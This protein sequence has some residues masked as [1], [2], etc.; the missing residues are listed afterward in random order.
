[1]LYL[2]LSTDKSLLKELWEYFVDRYF[3][4]DMPY[5]ENINISST[6]LNTL[7]L[8]IVG[9]TFGI[10][11]TAISTIFN[12]RYV[13]DFIRKLLYEECYDANSAKTLYELGYLKSPSIRSMIKT[14]GSLSRWVR[15]VEEDEFLAEQDAKRAEFE[16]AHKGDPNKPKFKEAE[17]KRELNTM[18]FYL[19]EGKKYAAEI[20]FDATGANLGSAILVIILAILLSAFMFYMLPDVIKLIDNFITVMKGN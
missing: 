16:E 3:S 1:M 11:I 13:G 15:C 4:L 20:K 19:P 12:K 7:R 18:H 9:L 14:G 8:L 17:F 6:T 5:L 2:A 10:I